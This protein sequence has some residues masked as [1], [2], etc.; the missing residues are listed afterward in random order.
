M[1]CLLGARA[2]QTARP[3][4]AAGARIIAHSAGIHKALVGRQPIDLRLNPARP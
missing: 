4:H 1:G 2:I 3:R